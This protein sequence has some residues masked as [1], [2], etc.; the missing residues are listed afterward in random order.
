MTT[1]TCKLCNNTIHYPTNS[2]P[3]FY[4]AECVHPTHQENLQEITHDEAYQE[5]QRVCSQT[6]R[7]RGYRCNLVSS[8]TY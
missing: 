8:F 1:T 6:H 3:V 7:P 2:W 4:C 5:H